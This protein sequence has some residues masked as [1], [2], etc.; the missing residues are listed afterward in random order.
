MGGNR[1]R[2]IDLTGSLYQEFGDT[3]KRQRLDF[4]RE[5]NNL[6]PTPNLP[7]YIEN[8]EILFGSALNDPLGGMRWN[9]NG[10]GSFDIADGTGGYFGAGSGSF[11]QN[12][13]APPR[14]LGETNFAGCLDNYEAFG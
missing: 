5:G 8:P 6:T 9:N 1:V 10:M 11:T 7:N 3:S 12:Y 13:F 2:S 4:D 14:I